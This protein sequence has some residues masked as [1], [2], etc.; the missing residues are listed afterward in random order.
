MWPNMNPAKAYGTME[1]STSKF[2]LDLVVG[3]RYD[4]LDIDTVAIDRDTCKFD[5][6]VLNE[7]Q[8]YVWVNSNCLTKF[9]P[10]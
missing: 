6:L 3:K 7:S 10:Y 5:Y 8:R 1:C 4:I 2:E 9:I